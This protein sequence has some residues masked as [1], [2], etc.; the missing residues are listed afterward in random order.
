MEHCGSHLDD[1]MLRTCMCEAAAIE[2]SRPF[3]VTYIHD[4][5]LSEPLTCNQLLIM[6]TK[7][8]LPPLGQ[9][10][11]ED[12]YSLKRWRRVQYLTNKFWIRWR[13]EFLNTL[14][15]RSKW[16]SSKRDMAVGYVV[17]IKD[18]NLL[19]NQWRLGRN[20]ECYTDDDGN[21]RKDKLVID[22]S[23]L[24]D[25]GKQQ[26]PVTYME[27]HFH[28]LVLLHGNSPPRGLINCVVLYI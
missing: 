26:E 8:I 6:K 14:Q 1:E 23:S 5:N 25:Y 3:S 2:N 27:R 19:R 21:V 7:I 24:H 9:F 18:E 15:T 16:T 11:R 22:S 12:F 17:L 28:K 4:P 10:Q 20:N 13:K